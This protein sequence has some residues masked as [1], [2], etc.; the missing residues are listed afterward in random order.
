[1]SNTRPERECLK[2]LAFEKSSSCAG[3][4]WYKQAELSPDNAKLLSA[5]RA[6]RYIETVLPYSSRPARKHSHAAK[7]PACRS[8]TSLLPV[9]QYLQLQHCERERLYCSA[10]NGLANRSHR[11]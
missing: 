10:A 5:F 2:H 1:N 4:H 8:R 9:A 7:T 11:A 6:S 3:P